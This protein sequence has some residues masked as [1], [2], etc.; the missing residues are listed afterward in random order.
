MVI[1]DLSRRSP[2]L[3]DVV[4]NTLGRQGE[5]DHSPHCLHVRRPICIYGGLAS[6]Q[7]EQARKIVFACPHA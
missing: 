4:L 1:N 2:S 3:V 6:E 7:S 5:I